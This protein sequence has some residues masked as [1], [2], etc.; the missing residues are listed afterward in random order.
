MSPQTPARVK[1]YKSHII[2]L[3]TDFQPGQYV[4]V[5]KAL[6]C[7]INPDVRIADL[8]HDI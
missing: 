2:V 4:E 7:S 8:C 1:L 5:T 6:S 3:L